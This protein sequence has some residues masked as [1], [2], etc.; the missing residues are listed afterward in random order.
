MAKTKEEKEE[1]KARKQAEKE[2]K[3]NKKG[4]D[5]D[6]KG[7]GFLI[8]LVAFLIFL[9][10]LGIAALLIKMDVGGFGSTVAYPALKNVPILNKILPEVEEYEEET[11]PYGYKSI[12][13]AVDRIKYLEKE[14]AKAKKK[15]KS[16]KAKG[17]ELEAIESEL[18]R[19]KDEEAAF[20][21]TKQ[22]FFEEVV[23]SDKA[24]DIE[25]YKEYYES[26]EP[27]N[28]EKLYKQ[29]IK[30]IQADQELE[31]YV[32]AYSAMKAEEAA[33]IFNTMTK[34]LG[35]VSKILKN[36]DKEARSKIL[37]KMDPETAAAV[38]K[39]MEP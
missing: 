38:T 12:A 3:K 28:A 9:V 15:N 25:T 6:E 23:Y 19:Y 8:F 2:A 18:Q 34:N 21:K 27:Q 35:L 26:I 11:D 36:M 17:E 7:G 14:L 32:A 13:E 37:G 39:L 31:D 4:G 33:G 22:K 30:D 24:P 29:V 16:A 5:D 20:E 1:E 10:W